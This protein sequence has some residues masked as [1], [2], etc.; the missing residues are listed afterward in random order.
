[1]ACALSRPPPP[2]KS[3]SKLTAS[4]GPYYS[5]IVTKPPPA[6]KAPD[7]PNKSNTTQVRPCLIR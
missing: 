2:S 1:M 6:R 3:P 4:T 7:P 5:P